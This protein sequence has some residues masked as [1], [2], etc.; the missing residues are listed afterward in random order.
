MLGAA[1]NIKMTELANTKEYKC[2]SMQKA[3]NDTSIA[4]EDV[5]RESKNGSK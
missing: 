3:D 4:M 2:G 1:T 5:E